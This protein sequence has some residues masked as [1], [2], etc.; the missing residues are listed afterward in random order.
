[1]ASVTQTAGTDA[2]QP[3]TAGP[4]PEFPW[5]HS[6]DAE[7]AVL[8]ESLLIGVD[9][10]RTARAHCEPADFF[11]DAHR[12]IFTAMDGLAQAGA[13]IDCLTVYERLAKSEALKSLGG[14]GYLGTLKTSETEATNVVHYARIVAD[15]AR[16]RQLMS[17][18]AVL[19]QRASIEDQTP[20]EIVADG[21]KLLAG[22]AAS[23]GD[24]GFLDLFDTPEE[25]E[26]AS[27]LTFAIKD[28]LQKDAAT[29]IAGLVGSYKTFVSLS[30]A[31][32][33]LNE[34][35]TLWDTFAVLHKAESVVYLIP[36]SARGPF[37]TRLELMG[38]MPYVRNHK[39]LV[40]TLN[41]GPI[42]PLQDARF[43]SGIRGAHVFVDTGIRFMAGS[44]NE[45][46][47][48]ARGLS[49][50]IL[51]M[52]AN[53][54]AS[55]VV[56]LHSP[57]GFETQNFMT[58]ENMVRGSG[59][60]GAPFATGWGVRHLPGDIV[61]VQNIKP[62][63]FEPRGPFQL[64]ARPY[65]DTTGDFFLWKAPGDCGTLVEEMPDTNRNAG[66][67]A[68]QVVREARSANL[69]LLSGFLKAEPDLNSRQIVQKFRELQISVS[70]SAIRKY[71][72]ELGV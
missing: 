2:V 66:G 26:T 25:I 20:A 44:E 23:N 68:P 64:A 19:Y 60:L 56:L 9:C 55:V 53:G 59:E 24:R 51:A 28:F 27:P 70:D 43:L 30:I 16:M 58:L 17:V 18:A 32:A 3:K 49:S 31:K 72:K 52:V 71:R 46:G 33:L 50:D 48:A 62:R 14:L 12:E 6:P 35:A 22:I 39:L 11:L 65:I 40:R 34:S 29:V 13:A 41:K 36:E 47:D 38:L 54:A 63:D 7:R 21:A 1:M 4:L 61:H 37:R 67:G 8:G 15:K 5:P 42:L 57:K 10:F 45:A 69:A